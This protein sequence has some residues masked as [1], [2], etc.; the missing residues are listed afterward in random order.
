MASS[1][2]A[3]LLAI[4]FLSLSAVAAPGDFQVLVR[5]PSKAAA[6]RAEGFQVG[7]LPEGETKEP[8]PDGLARD[9]LQMKHPELRKAQRQ[10]RH[11]GF[12]VDELISRAAG[13]RYSLEDLRGLYPMF[14]ADFLAKLRES[15]RDVLK[16]G[17]HQ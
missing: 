17:A 15:S 2:L 6:F 11:D 7:V 9:Q 16:P 1:G 10:G 12:W 8:W 13:E 14:P 5:D 4:S 3:C